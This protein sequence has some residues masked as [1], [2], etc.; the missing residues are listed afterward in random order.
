MPL[1]IQRKDEYGYDLAYKLAGERLAGLT[2]ADIEAQ[3]QRCDA[4]CETADSQQKITL[5]YLGRDYLI[6]LSPIAISLKG[7]GENVPLRDKI[8]ILHYF[9][10]ARGTPLTGK[11]L[12]YREL[13]EGANYLSTFALRAIKPLL[14]RFSKEPER[15]VEAAA[16]VGGHQAAFGDVAVTIQAFPRVP[17]TFVLW[18]GDDEFPP[19]G[20]ILFDSSVPDYLSTED[21][22][23]LCEAIAWK[24]VRSVKD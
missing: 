13:P 12:A 20:N 5:P 14:T 18:L 19:D 1:P 10:Q 24:L 9:T 22:N 2:A 15:L 8:L 4:R 16:K 17:I 3:C 6:T 21:I 11:L 23:V 7:S